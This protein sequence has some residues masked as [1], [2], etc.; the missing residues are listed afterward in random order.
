MKQLGISAKLLGG[1]ML[2]SPIFIRLAGEAAE[3]TMAS[4]A[5]LPL[6]QMPGGK[7][8]QARYR[9]RFKEEVDVYSPYAYDATRVLVAAMQRA[10]STDPATYL[11]ELARTN[12]SGV[13]S[14]HIAYDE[15][16]DIKGAAMTLYR[17]EGGDWQVM[18]VEGNGPAGPL[19][20]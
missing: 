16:G 2:K 4:L 6:A 7:D 1:E 15:R 11:P 3:G 9:A 8:Y 18:A 13:T 10:D 12:H 14:P 5:G 17:V 20:P 19:G